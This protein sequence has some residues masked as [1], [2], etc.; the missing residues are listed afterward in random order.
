MPDCGDKGFR[1]MLSPEQQLYVLRTAKGDY[2][3]SR[4]PW[5]SMCHL[6]LFI[7]MT[8]VTWESSY[9]YLAV[10][11]CTRLASGE[12]LCLYQHHGTWDVGWTYLN[13]TAMWTAVCK[14][15]WLTRHWWGPLRKS[16]LF[17][18][19]YLFL[20]FSPCVSASVY[21]SLL[22]SLSSLPFS[23]CLFVCLGVSLSLCVSLFSLFSLSS[24]V[25]SQTHSSEV[26]DS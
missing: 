15:D 2:V 7:Q 5:I 9:F 25:C 4:E 24:T 23:L 18:S 13:I 8:N 11:R 16:A 3:N 6:F 10:Q 1:V 22:G 21:L 12:A 26:R 20:S 17:F 14:C 19:L